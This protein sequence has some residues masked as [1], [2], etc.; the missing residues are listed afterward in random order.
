LSIKERID[1]G[2]IITLEDGYKYYWPKGCTGC[3]SAENLREIAEVLD[4][5]NQ[6]WQAD[7]ENYMANVAYVKERIA[8]G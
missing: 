3:F 4:E 8:E 7:I 6:G 1:P 5:K 2:E